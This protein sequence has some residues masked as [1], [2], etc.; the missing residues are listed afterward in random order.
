MALMKVTD[1]T[2][3]VEE[4]DYRMNVGPP[5]VVIQAD[6]TT[7]LKRYAAQLLAL[8]ALTDPALVDKV[9]E[10]AEKIPTPES[11]NWNQHDAR[12]IL[13]SVGAP[14][15]PSHVQVARVPGHALLLLRAVAAGSKGARAVRYART[16]ASLSMLRE[17]RAESVAVA[18]GTCLEVPVKLV[19]GK[20]GL[21]LALFLRRQRTRTIAEMERQEQSK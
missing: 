21:M 8:T 6:G 20:E 3:T 11:E 7:N 4:K 5:E 9:R 12:L 19:E 2:L 13:D 18:E 14:P 17:L 10:A 16:R 15:A 1:L